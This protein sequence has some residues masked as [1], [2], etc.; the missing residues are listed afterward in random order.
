M[1]QTLY[2]EIRFEYDERRK[3]LWKTLCNAYF[4]KLIRPE[5]HVLELGAGYGHFINHVRCA[6]R[7]AIDRW[8]RLPSLVEPG[9]EAHVGS[10]TDLEFIP[11]GTVD[12]AFASNLFEHLT[13]EEFATI[14]AG[15]KRKLRAGG[16][17]TILQPNYK[18]AY[19]EYFDDY[20]HITVYSDIS[21]CDF[22]RANGYRIISSTPGFLPFSLKS[23][24]P[25]AG[26]LVRL[27]LLLPWKPFAKQMLIRSEPD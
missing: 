15:L 22:L 9:V 7:T 11:D 6:K 13:Q 10:A 4:S 14:L 23:R 12:F 26:W 19:R 24:F 17:L 27:Y 3:V 2:H 8:E 21:L 25:V 16:T 18:L 1:T 5:F 20:T